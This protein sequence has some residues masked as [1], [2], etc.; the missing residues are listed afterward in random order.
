MMGILSNVLYYLTRKE[1]LV[2]EC[3]ILHISVAFSHFLMEVDDLNHA[4][5]L[6]NLIM[7][8]YR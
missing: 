7:I 6:F 8:D 2:V 4:L 5:V 1:V 3:A